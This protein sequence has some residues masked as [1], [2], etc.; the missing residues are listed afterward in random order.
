METKTRKIEEKEESDISDSDMDSGTAFI[1]MKRVYTLEV[2]AE[3]NKKIILHNQSDA[4]Y[5][6]DLR[7]D[8]L[9]DNQSTL[10]LSATR[11]EIHV[12]LYHYV[13]QETSGGYR[14][15]VKATT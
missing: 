9:L 13:A 4:I 5:Q 8:I 7:S 11:L 14:Q 1:Q 2:G 3:L 12:I 15:V 10:D 6:L